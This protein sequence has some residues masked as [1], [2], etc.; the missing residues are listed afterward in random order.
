MPPKSRNFAPKS[1]DVYV[2]NLTGLSAKFHLGN[3]DRCLK[4]VFFFSFV[5]LIFLWL[6]FLDAT[7]A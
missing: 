1:F 6:F 3:G 5:K 4:I 7:Y 2:L